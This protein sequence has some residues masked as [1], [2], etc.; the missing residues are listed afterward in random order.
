[1]MM[2]PGPLDPDACVTLSDGVTATR[3]GDETVVLDAR[4]GRY[5]GLEAVGSRVWALLERG[6]T[7]NELAR[8]VADEYDV[9]HEA[10]Q[11]DIRALLS[12]L[13]SAGLITACP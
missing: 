10:C 12:D 8:I 4:A 3:L 9:E 6:A 13:Q 7:L 11:R 1:M 5:F 2:N